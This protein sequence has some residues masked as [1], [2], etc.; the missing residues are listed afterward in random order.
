MGNSFAFSIPPKDTYDIMVGSHRVVL[1]WEPKFRIPYLVL[2]VVVPP[3]PLISN[4]AENLYAGMFEHSV[5]CVPSFA[6]RAG[7]GSEAGG[8]LG[9]NEPLFAAVS[10]RWVPSFNRLPA[11]TAFVP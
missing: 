8:R 10:F 1:A 7:F 4:S 6:G 3:V 11:A 5:A 9:Q 2:D